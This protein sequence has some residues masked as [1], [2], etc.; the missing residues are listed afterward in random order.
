MEVLSR[1]R[2]MKAIM[3]N[4]RGLLAMV[5]ISV[6]LFFGRRLA[7]RRAVFFMAL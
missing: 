1:E 6:R 2:S 4:G 3:S 5:I 7:Q